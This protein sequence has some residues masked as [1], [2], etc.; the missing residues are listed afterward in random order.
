MKRRTGSGWPI[1]VTTDK[2]AELVEELICSQEDF[3]G[4]HKSPREIDRNV[5][6]S[7]TST[8]KRGGQR[9]FFGEEVSEK[10]KNQSV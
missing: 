7:R 3:P 10:K 1:T 8:V 6:I 4:T 9:N 2:D 5:G